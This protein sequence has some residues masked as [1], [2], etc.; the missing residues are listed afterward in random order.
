MATRG[1]RVDPTKRITSTG[2][3]QNCGLLI[4]SNKFCLLQ[5]TKELNL[6]RP[7]RPKGAKDRQPR[8]KCISMAI[9]VCDRS[10]EPP[11]DMMDQTQ[12]TLQDHQQPL[13]IQSTLGQEYLY[14]ES[15]ESGL[16]QLDYKSEFFS[17]IDD[18]LEPFHDYSEEGEKWSKNEQNVVADNFIDPFHDDWPNW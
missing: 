14:H 4:R 12:Q 10:F 8:Q 7:G 11:V 5:E 3:N 18:A 9:S 17:L 2:I 13:Q 6:R 15:D 1:G 16:S